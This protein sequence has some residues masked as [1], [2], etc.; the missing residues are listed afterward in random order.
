MAT[1][2]EPP[3]LLGL[4]ER[5]AQDVDGAE[6]DRLVARLRKLRQ[7][8]GRQMDR[9]LPP[10]QFRRAAVIRDGCDAAMEIVPRL[11]GMLHQQRN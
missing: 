8:V 9:G 1:A 7:A 5:L 11:W 10:G 2:T 4:E 3:L 6:R